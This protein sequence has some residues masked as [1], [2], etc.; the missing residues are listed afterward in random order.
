MNSFHKLL[1]LPKAVKHLGAESVWPYARYQF[2][3]H[4]GL[5][6]LQTPPHYKPEH[7]NGYPLANLV[8]PAPPTEIEILNRTYRNQLIS[9]AEEILRGQV[10]LF[11][12]EPVALDLMAPQP[13]RHWTAYHNRI[14]DGSDI[15]PVW[16]VGRFGWATTLTRAYWIS[17]DEKYA[18]GFWKLTSEFLESNPPNRGPHWSSAQEIALRTIAIAFSYSLVSE[19]SA[20]T[21][22]RKALLAK[23]IAAHAD[24]MTLTFDYSRAQNNNHF[25]SEAVGLWTAGSLIPGHPKAEQWRKLGRQLFAEGIEKQVHV[26]GRYVQHS[27][28]YHRLMLQL[29]LWAVC[30]TKMEGRELGSTTLGNLSKATNWLMN[31]L[32]DDSGR[33]PNLGPNDGAYVLPLTNQPFHDHRPVIQASSSAFLKTR[34]LK[35]GP[36]N[37]MML[38]LGIQ[39]GKSAERERSSDNPIRIEGKNSWAYLR[40]TYFFERPGHADQLHLDLWWRG[41]NIAQD[42]GSFLYTAEEPWNNALATTRVHNTVTVERKDQMT[43]AGRFLWLDWAQARMV[44]AHAKAGNLTAAIAEHNGYMGL[45]I[46][47]RRE[48]SA[49]EDNWNIVDRLF[50]PRGKEEGVRA[51]LHWLLP[52]FPF[53][54]DKEE[55]EIMTNIGNIKLRIETN[56]DEPPEFRLIRAGELVHGSAPADPV[57]GWVSPTYGVKLPAL[58]L[59]VDISGR[60]PVTI[61]STWTLSE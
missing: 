45:G 28:N 32:D 13:L 16:E 55:V 37:D 38:W 46:I 24:R 3:L 5:L 44:S 14:P 48:V 56:A 17:Q 4:S 52:D 26:D 29:G 34:P 2:R 49:Q 23:N 20:S 57:L 43:K 1:L 61:T 31:L 60:T 27:S 21:D 25:L 50:R 42:A 12:S 47:H 36:W 33:V 22:D 39:P 6:R 10:R 41:V 9:A 15:K 53:Q 54:I 8:S 35:T 51:R 59:N 58:S 40:R 7:I 30:L 18:E 11:G 19:S